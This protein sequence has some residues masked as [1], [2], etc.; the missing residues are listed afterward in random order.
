[1]EQGTAIWQCSACHRLRLPCHQA[2]GIAQNPHTR[3][4]SASLPS[5]QL[6]APE[7]ARSSTFF[8]TEKPSHQSGRTGAIARHISGLVHSGVA[9]LIATA[10]CTCSSTFYFPAQ[11]LSRAHTSRWGSHCPSHSFVRFC[12][13]RTAHSL[14]K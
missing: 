1:M 4:T 3:A 9:L 8:R 2:P 6:P 12:F 14:H 10:D 7:S 5:H 11:C 13:G